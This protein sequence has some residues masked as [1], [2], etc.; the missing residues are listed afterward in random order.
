MSAVGARGGSR[1][2]TV[3]G[4]SPEA[5]VAALT[6]ALGAAGERPTAVI[7]FASWRFDPER[8]AAALDAAFAPAAV[9]GCTSIGELGEDGD[10]E[11]TISALALC[12][13]RLR[14][15]VALAP[16]LSRQALRSSR[17][18]V[19]DAAAALGYAPDEL[20]PRRHVAITLVDG[21]CGFEESFCL[22]SASTAPQIRFVGG[23]ASDGFLPEPATRVFFG[24]RAYGDAGVVAVL[25]PDQPFAVIESEHMIPTELRTVVT[26]ADHRHRIVHELDGM[27]AARRY[28][29]LIHESGGD[30]IVDDVVASSYPFAAY[31][32]GRPYVRSVARVDGD[33]LH[34]A[35]AIEVGAVLRLMRPGDL[36]GT[37]ERA[38]AAAAAEVGGRPAAVLAFSCLGRH[39]EAQSRD[40]I[41]PLAALYRRAPLIG[42]HSFGEQAG[43]LLVNHTLT[44]LVLGEPEGRDA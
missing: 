26:A 37:T 41:G 20:D 13:P 1:R 39:R 43:A 23:S 25:E 17:A 34:F 28:Q 12:S 22:G 7:A 18:A 31:V 24:G 29:E 35:C 36:V 42:F 9:I 10:R 32:G 11:G 8:T 2:V 33:D 30:E 16:E 3:S 21:R 38:L 5:A 44:G 40:L 15:G 14:V 6:Q 27:P 19:I 4:E